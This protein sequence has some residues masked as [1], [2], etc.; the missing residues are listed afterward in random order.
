M[1]ETLIAFI[2][3]LIIG[4]IINGLLPGD[5]SGSGGG[6]ATAPGA[7]TPSGQSGG[8]SYGGEQSGNEI[9]NAPEVTTVT[10]GNFDSE[11]LQ[12]KQP[13]LIDFTRSNCVHCR[14]MKPIVNQLAQ[15]YAG[16]LKVV[17]VDVMD[18]PAIANR[19][20]INAVPAFLIV[21]KGRAEGPFLGEM[22]VEKLKALLR[23]HLG[24]SVGAQPASSQGTQR[25]S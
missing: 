21:D 6:G 5:T 15:E 22:P 20:E 7:G 12:D 23:P 4:S 14:K 24:L 16:S 17:Q 2:I 1:K 9:A 19:Y 3:A 25:S 8:T 11:V 10:E 13:V 18:N